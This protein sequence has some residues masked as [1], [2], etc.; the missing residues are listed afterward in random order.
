MDEIGGLLDGPRARGAFLLR[1]V[2][3]PPWSLRIQDE[4]PLAVVAVTRGEAWMRYDDGR[5]VQLRRGDLAITVGAQEYGIADMA[6]RSPEVIIGPGGTCTT[7]AGEHVPTTTF[8]GVRTW[9]NSPSGSTEVLVGNYL[10]SSTL[11]ARLLA[12]LPSLIVLPEYGFDSPVLAMLAQEISKD[13]P[14]QEVVLDRLLDLLLVAAL[15]SWFD[16]PD[17]Q[18]PGW[19]AA[20]ADPVVGPVLRAM[21]AE[22]ATNW[23]VASLAERARV[24]RA[25]LA[26][27]F[28]ELV[29]QPPMT[30]LA[31]WRL[32]VA[33]DLLRDTDATLDTVARRVGYGSGFA[34]STAFK[35]VH[36]ISPREHRAARAP[37]PVSS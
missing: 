16:R 24:S 21:Q 29:G 17:A 27:R 4:V 7:P 35:R 14:G 36:G 30:F 19:Y 6:G 10:S 2:M 34:L 15:R 9:G 13:R 1:M 3:E 5:I 32:A 23:T 26:R 22:P 31:G 12:G 18:T 11:G 33:A 8:F 28:T 20:S 25:G 37:V